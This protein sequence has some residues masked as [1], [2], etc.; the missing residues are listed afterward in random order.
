MCES[1]VSGYQ[2]SVA[3]VSAHQIEEPERPRRTGSL[4]V[5][6]WSSS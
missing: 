4:A 6:N 1:Q 3:E 2:P 5:T